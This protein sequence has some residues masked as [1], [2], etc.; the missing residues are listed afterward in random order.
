MILRQNS[1]ET[2][3]WALIVT[4]TLAAAVVATWPLPADARGG[5]GFGGHG[6]GRAFGGHGMPGAH[7]AGGGHRHGNDS[8]MKA[9]SD[10]R[11]KLLN[12]QIKSICRGC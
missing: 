4:T 1:L 11:D 3:R 2:V 10:D 8:Y 6:M 9:A 12:T 7:S 5:H